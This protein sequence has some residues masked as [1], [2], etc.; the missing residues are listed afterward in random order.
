[1]ENTKFWEDAAR[2]GAYVGLAQAAFTELEAW[3]QSGLLS[4]LHIVVY[5]ALLTVFTRRRAKLYGG[6]NGYSYGKCL[7]FIFFMSLF[8]GVMMGAY[9]IAASNFIRPEWYRQLIGSTVDTLAA[10]KLYTQQ[11]LKQ[12]QGLYEKMFFSPIWVVV[13]CVCSQVVSGTF[14]GLFI[15]AFTRREAPL[16]GG[17]DEAEEL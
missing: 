5:V 15:S 8:A 6:R 3:H 1:M 10:T 12:V 16:Y 7:K 4:L 11:M 9:T 13:T 17:N 14:F 2:Y